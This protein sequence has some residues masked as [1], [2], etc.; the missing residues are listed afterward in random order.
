MKPSFYLNSKDMS[1]VNSILEVAQLFRQ[2]A[3]QEARN[4]LNNL[5]KKGQ[6]GAQYVDKSDSQ[7][8]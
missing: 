6:I 4:I 8:P 1:V 7:Q 2:K 3:D 5:L